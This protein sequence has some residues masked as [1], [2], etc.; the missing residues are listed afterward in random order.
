[1]ESGPTS[2]NTE[3]DNDP[4]SESKETAEISILV[5]EGNL[6][7][8]GLGAELPPSDINEEGSEKLLAHTIDQLKTEGLNISLRKAKRN[9]RFRRKIG[10]LS[11]INMNLADVSYMGP[12]NSEQV[13]PDDIA[14]HRGYISRRNDRRRYTRN[15]EK[16]EKYRG[17]IYDRDDLLQD[18]ASARLRQSP[19]PQTTE[20]TS[21][22][23][24]ISE[25]ALKL[26]GDPTRN[27]YKGQTNSEKALIL[28]VE[29]LLANGARALTPE[30]LDET[31]AAL[32]DNQETRT[33]LKKFTIVRLRSL[34]IV[35]ADG[36]LAKTGDELR[37]QLTS[38][39]NADE[40]PDKEDA[41]GVI[42][43][44]RGQILPD[45]QIETIAE[46]VSKAVSAHTGA[47]GSTGS[48]A[49]KEIE[50]NAIR[51][52]LGPDASDDDID[53]VREDIKSLLKRKSQ[54]KT[55]Q[56]SR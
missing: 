5:N 35:S 33:K 8:S 36:R 3:T 42:R 6:A 53:S 9:D 26:L 55:H 54:T 10:S 13:N 25:S 2:T 46:L 51:S 27:P 38:Y 16:I 12:V 23:K 15:L 28:S 22:V 45:A 40:R 39:L 11:A 24:S 48:T 20:A 31:L 1:M 41:T 32:S 34:G 18:T 14:K 56:R 52:I 19:I 37:D 17:K 44:A 50:L 30:A 4:L 47:Y 7:V 29:S 49:A 43:V 21:Q